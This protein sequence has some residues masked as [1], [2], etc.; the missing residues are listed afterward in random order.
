MVHKLR[1]AELTN[2]ERRASTAANS[3][4]LLKAKALY[5]FGSTFFYLIAQIFSC[6]GVRDRCKHRRDISTIDYMAPIDEQAFLVIIKLR[7][8]TVHRRM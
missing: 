7:A 4:V 1:W 2:A 6:V 5:L 8:A 3:I